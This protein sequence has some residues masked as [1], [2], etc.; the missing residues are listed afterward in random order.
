MDEK[1]EDSAQLS[2]V[3]GADKKAI[4][5]YGRHACVSGGLAV[6]VPTLYCRAVWQTRSTTYT[7]C[8]TRS[9]VRSAAAATALPERALEGPL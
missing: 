5:K 6:S 7:A 9:R 8:D 4:E 2:C 3:L 1:P